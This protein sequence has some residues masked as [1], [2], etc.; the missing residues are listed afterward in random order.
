[1][2][3]VRGERNVIGLD[4]MGEAAAWELLHVRRIALVPCDRVDPELGELRS[5]GTSAGRDKPARSSL[6]LL[7]APLVHIHHP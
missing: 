7:D 6:C 5:I 3:G 4:P 2:R 1:M